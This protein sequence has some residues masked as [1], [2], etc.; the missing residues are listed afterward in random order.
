M[1][2][3]LL[4]T[5]T[6]IA[7]GALPEP[8]HQRDPWTPPASQDIPEW[9]TTASA[10]LFQAG[11]ADP[12]GGEYR[13]I[14]LAGSGARTHGWVF[15][16]NY[17]VCWNGLV[18]RVRSIGQPADLAR[19]ARAVVSVDRLGPIVRAPADDA[20]FWTHVEFVDARAPISLVLMLRLGEIDLARQALPIYERARLI[21]EHSS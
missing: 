8:P 20:A 5:C 11:V 12:R 1:R 16:G 3:V 9:V 21:V 19:D 4:L 13:E 7:R 15:E 18:Y 17:A 6:L 14:E 10:L 2:R